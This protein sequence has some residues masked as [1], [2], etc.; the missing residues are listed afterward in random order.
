MTDDELDRALFA[1]PLEEPPADLHQ[2]ILAAT[3]QR[4]APAFAVWERWLLAVALALTVAVTFWLFHSTP[5]SLHR[6]G[7]DVVAG[8]RGLGLFNR[9][10]YVWLG[11]GISSVWW[12]SSLNFMPTPRSTV[13]NR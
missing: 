4:P 2:R 9:A 6:L 10:T 12:I 5:G 8:M 13:Y 11:I 7:G 1:L 3:V